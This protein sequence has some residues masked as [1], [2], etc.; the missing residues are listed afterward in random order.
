MESKHAARP[1]QKPGKKVSPG[2]IKNCLILIGKLVHD[3]TK[4]RVP[5]KYVVPTTGYAYLEKDEDVT[6]FLAHCAAGWFKV[7]AALALYAGLRKGEI[8]GLRRGDVKDAL[9][10]IEVNF[11]FDGRPVKSK[12]HRYVSLPPELRAILDPWIENMSPEQLVITIDGKPMT[13]KYDIASWADRVSRRAGVPRINFHQTRHTYGSHLA[14]T[15]SLAVVGALMGHIDPKTTQRYAHM[16]TESLARSP[17]MHL[18][19]GAA[20]APKKRRKKAS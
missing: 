3:L 4:R 14:K 7:A 15:Q 5:F 6:A 13:K 16:N 18:S 1:G 19:F 10:L 2:Q 12:H 9:G 17:A 11:T 20:A 8:A